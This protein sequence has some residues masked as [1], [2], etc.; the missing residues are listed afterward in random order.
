M[1]ETNKSQPSIV[2]E[3]VATYGRTAPAH[4]APSTRKPFKI[5]GVEAP[6]AVWEFAKKHELF[7]Y[8]EMVIQWVREFFPTA[9]NITLGYGIDYEGVGL[10]C[11]EIEFDVSDSVEKVL[12]QYQQLNQERAQRLPL[13]VA[14]K[15]TF[16]IGWV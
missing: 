9:R 6:D 4:D 8:L 15:I 11:I 16:M 7:P 3:A 1:S 14:E 13:D 5:A 2:A 10:N 12:E